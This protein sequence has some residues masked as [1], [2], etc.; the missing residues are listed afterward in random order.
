MHSRVVRTLAASQV[1]GHWVDSQPPWT[2]PSLL[3]QHTDGCPVHSANPPP[4]AEEWT[5]IP[6]P[7]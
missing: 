5:D 7:A 6:S 3:L 1:A 2:D 4:D